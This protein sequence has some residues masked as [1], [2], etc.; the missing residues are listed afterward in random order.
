MSPRSQ[1]LNQQLREQSRE[2]ILA[3]ALE[4]FADEGYEGATI[5]QITDRAQVSRGLISYYF[6]SKRDLLAT[7]LDRWLTGVFSLLDGAGPDVPADERLRSL[8]DLVLSG[9]SRR[10]GEQRLMLCLMLQPGTHEVYARVEGARE[11]DARVFED[12]LRALFAERGAAEPA[13]EEVL[14]RSVLEGVL[15]KLIV[16]PETYP[17]AAVRARLY[18]L[19]GLGEPAPLDLPGPP[20]GAAVRLRM[21]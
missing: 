14:L 2:R 3:A 20:V 4:V 12:K 8:I 13:V 10:P 15:F 1:R 18:Q 5:S 11:P 16:Y 21:G 6:P 9:A 7:V 17:L 19:Y